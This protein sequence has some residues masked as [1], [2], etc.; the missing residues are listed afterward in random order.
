LVDVYASMIA[1]EL[2]D[3][4]EAQRRSHELDP[5]TISSTVWRASHLI[6]LARGADLDGSREA[7]LHLLIRAADAS[8]ET[9]QY[10]PVARDLIERMVKD[11]GAT[12]RPDVEALARRTGILTS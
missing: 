8:T 7:T 3:P 1:V 6:M 2:G 5:D 4:D 9:V 10:S 12:I 11:A